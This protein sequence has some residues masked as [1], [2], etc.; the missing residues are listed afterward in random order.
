MKFALLALALLSPLF[1]PW[2]LTVGLALLAAI[3]F[4]FAPF[5]VGVLTDVLYY[6]HGASVLPWWTLLGALAT[7][8]AFLVRGFVQTSIMRA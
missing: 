1:F 6:A 7:A 2:P 8:V 4:P 3:Y 5:V